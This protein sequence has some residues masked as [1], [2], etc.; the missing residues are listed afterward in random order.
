MVL[1]VTVVTMV[2]MEMWVTVVMMILAVTTVAILLMIVM[3]T[4]VVILVVFFEMVTVSGE[5]FD[6]QAS[7]GKYDLQN[8]VCHQELSV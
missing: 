3:V 1:M 7:E 8:I 2:V 5:V 4:T 6:A